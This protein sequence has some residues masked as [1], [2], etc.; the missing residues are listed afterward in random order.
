MSVEASSPRATY[1]G[2]G[3]GATIPSSR[4]KKVPSSQQQSPRLS[5]LPGLKIMDL[6][7]TFLA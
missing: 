1:A 7:D 3:G 6:N 2:I 4:K 5:A